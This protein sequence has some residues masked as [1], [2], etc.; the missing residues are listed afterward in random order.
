M[1]AIVANSSI[2]GKSI[3]I[4][5]RN[6]LGYQADPYNLTYTIYR[7]D[8][9]KA[10]GSNLRP[11]KQDTGVFYAPWSCD[12]AGG[13]FKVVWKYQNSLNGPI[14]TKSEEF[15]VIGQNNFVCYGGKAVPLDDGKNACGGACGVLFGGQLTGPNDL[16]IYLTNSH[17]VPASAY[18]IQWQIF[19][20]N[21]CPITPLTNACSDGR[22]G[23][24][25]AYWMVNAQSGDYTIKW[26]VKETADSPLQE[27]CHKFSVINSNVNLTKLFGITFDS[28]PVNVCDSVLRAVSCCSEKCTGSMTHFPCI[29]VAYSCPP[30]KP[31]SGGS[32]T[33]ISVPRTIH[34]V[35]QSLPAG[36]AFTSQNKF[37]IPSCISKIA[38][39]IKY[40]RGSVGGFPILR[41]FWGDGSSEYQQTLITSNFIEPDSDS[42][43]QDMFLNDLKGPVPENDNPIRFL[44]ELSVPG[45]QTTVR[46]LAAE[47][48]VQGAPGTCEIILT[49]SA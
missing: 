44:L 6:D 23:C 36:G 21:C 5:F 10:S 37:D 27:F 24:Y 15:Y 41:L 3:R 4:S 29:Q 32:A 7:Q 46:L 1:V 16:K 18:T 22:L 42:S 14:K 17:G 34:L 8:G 35:E 13:C 43:V 25:W 11:V 39:N 45:G 28:T 47:G 26:Y 40:R 31:P 9:K 30:A 19:D 48:G 38:F 12:N 20:C 33:C 2:A 49:G